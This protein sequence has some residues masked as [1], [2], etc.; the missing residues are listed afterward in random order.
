MMQQDEPIL[1]SEHPAAI[2][3][4]HKLPYSF[5][6]PSYINDCE[7][8]V[9]AI[10]DGAQ[11]IFPIRFVAEAAR[12][13]VES[14]LERGIDG[15]ETMG[16]DTV[17]PKGVIAVVMLKR[18]ITTGWVLAPLNLTDIRLSKPGRITRPLSSL[19]EDG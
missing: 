16:S 1:W 19:V 6:D 11:D 5:I 7:F 18:I 4:S 12:G 2:Y 13:I 15:A 8:V 14:C 3:R 10:E 17:G 9:A